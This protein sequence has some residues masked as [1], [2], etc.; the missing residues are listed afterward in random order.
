MT[1]STATVASRRTAPRS[2][3]LSGQSVPPLPSYVINPTRIAR[4]Q[5]RI[6]VIGQLSRSAVGLADDGEGHVTA[7]WTARLVGDGFR[8]WQ[9]VEDT[10]E[11]RRQLDL[12]IE[13]S[14]HGALL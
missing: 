3:R 6:A 14:S 1:Q 12:E 10:P 11:H 13:G 8:A 7:I 5:N 9:M 2:D 4:H